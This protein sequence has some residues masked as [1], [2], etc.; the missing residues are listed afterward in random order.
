MFKIIIASLFLISFIG[1]AQNL[2]S[3]PG[4][5]Q[6]TTC[7]YYVSQ[8]NFCDGWEQPTHGTS[9]YFNACL[10]VPFSVSVPD[11]QFGVQ[12]PS[13]GNGYAGLYAFYSTTPFTTAPDGDHEYITSQLLHP[14]QPG[15]TYYAE[16]KISLSEASKYAVSELGILFSMTKPVRND[17]FAIQYTPQVTNI[18]SAPLNNKSDWTTIS[19]CFVADSAYEFITIGNFRTGINTVFTHVGSQT[20]NLHYSYYYIDDILVKTIDKPIIEASAIACGPVTISITNQNNNYQYLWS[21][22]STTPSIVVTNSGYYWCSVFTGECWVYSDSIEVNIHQPIEFS[23]GNDTAINFCMTEQWSL[24][25]DIGGTSGLHFEWSTGATT[26]QIIITSPGTYTLTV[27]DSNGC[28]ATSSVKVSDAC[29]G[30]LFVPNAFTPNNDGK[31]DFFFCYGINIGL[32]DF[33]IYNRWGERVCQ[34]D[35]MVDG[36]DGNEAPGGL[37]VWEAVFYKLEDSHPAPYFRAGNVL[38]MR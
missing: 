32:K 7:P 13:G 6:Y 33:S 18:P 28:K 11:N 29:D 10:G 14:L 31:N 24:I 9:D 30:G 8:V 4:F 3:N 17:E 26:E 2:V 20:S 5:E 19:G 15:K 16:F 34:T 23:L 1:N 22:G 37:Y 36:W 38:L 27:S 25:P 35:K 21:D 12:Q